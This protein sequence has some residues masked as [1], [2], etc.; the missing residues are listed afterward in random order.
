MFSKFVT[1]AISPLGTSLLLGL[2]AWCCAW[3][4][5]RLWALR[6]GAFALLWLWCWSTPVASM[7]LRGQIEAAYPPVPITDLAP[8][9][10]LVVLGGGIEVPQQAG[11]QPN[12]GAAA[13]RM[14]H[15]ARLYKAGKAPVVVLSG[16]L[17]FEDGLMSEAASMR[18]FMHDLGVPDSAM[19]LEERSVNTRQNAHYTAALLRERGISQIVL[20]TSALH[21]RRSALLFEAQG[22]KVT[23]AATDHEYRVYP[24]WRRLLPDADAL[25]GSGRAMKEWVGAMF[26]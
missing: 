2:W 17:A 23:P 13:D 8:A 9:Q 19:V 26:I 21:M 7:W 24:L 3:R 10:A 20:V 14:W 22:L 11:A 4:G 18:A 12:L 1:F 6:C 15:A 25:D 16:G 5:H